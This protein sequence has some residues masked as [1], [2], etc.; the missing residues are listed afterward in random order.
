MEQLPRRER[1]WELDAFRGLCILCVILVHAVFDLRYFAHLS[2][3]V[4]PI[5]QFVMDYGGM[6]FVLLSG[7]CVTL[8]SHSVRRGAVVFGCGLLI[9]LV[10]TT[11]VRLGLATR[12]LIIQFG[13]LHLLGFCMIV[14]PLYKKL[15]A[16]AIAVLG[17]AF[18]ILGFVFN[19]ILVDGTC[20]YVLGLRYPGF[21]AGDY[22]P[23]FPN[24]G[25]FMLGVTLGR[26]AYRNRASLL[27]R[28]PKDAWPIRFLSFCGRQSLWIY[29]L[30]QPVIYGILML[31]I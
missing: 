6:L 28:A 4:S 9:T 30:H 14:Y 12:D 1:I 19:T 13:V 27:P 3:S 10:T 29:L 8:G 31:V 11:M 5:L 26:T 2:F 20:W 24:L 7:V 25:W 16:A 18:V 17:V 23:I 21:E 15:P 22:F